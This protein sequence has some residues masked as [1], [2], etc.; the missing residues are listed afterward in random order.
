LAPEIPDIPDW[1]TE[2]DG[3]KLKNLLGGAGA[4]I[5]IGEDPFGWFEENIVEV[6]LSRVVEG[7]LYIGGTIAATILDAYNQLAL[8]PGLIAEPVTDI[9]EA[10]VMAVEGIFGVITEVLVEATSA[11]GPL[12]PLVTVVLWLVIL[13][14]LIRLVSGLRTVA[15][16]I[17]PW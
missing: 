4:L 14:L 17:N 15:G 7:I 10:V 12:A 16:V 8:V 1:V 5:A 9:G 6:A 3:E 2:I 11:A 13:V